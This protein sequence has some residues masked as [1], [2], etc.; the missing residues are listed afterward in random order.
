MTHQ[1]DS[2]ISELDK[3]LSM[4]R[5][6]WME[7]RDDGEKRKNTN[8]LN[9]LLDERLR[10]MSARDAASKLNPLPPTT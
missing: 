4:V 6:F 5:T 1:Y 7:A 10:L 2:L 9:E 3:T 8:R